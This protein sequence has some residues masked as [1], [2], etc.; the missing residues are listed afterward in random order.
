MGSNELLEGTLGDDRNPLPR[1][2]NISFSSIECLRCRW[3]DP[4]ALRPKRL[5]RCKNTTSSTF[6]KRKIGLQGLQKPANKR[7]DYFCVRKS[8]LYGINEDTKVVTWWAKGIWSSSGTDCSN[9]GVSKGWW[10][11][12]VGTNG[13][14]GEWVAHCSWDH[15]EIHRNCKKEGIATGDNGEVSTASVSTQASPTFSRDGLGAVAK[16]KVPNEWTLSTSNG[17]GSHSQSKIGSSYPL[18]KIQ[19]FLHMSSKNRFARLAILLIKDL[20][21][22]LRISPDLVQ[23]L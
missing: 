14:Y 16:I 18:A 12:D 2:T 11:W 21:L 15:K 6:V 20:H 1:T 13:L 8:V 17:V 3:F 7:L 22:Y 19:P 23:S 5:R 9:D 4:R 10:R